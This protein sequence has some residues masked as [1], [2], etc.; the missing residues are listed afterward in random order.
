MR[1]Q[2]PV[3]RQRLAS[4]DGL[5]T[6]IGVRV[7]AYEQSLVTGPHVRLADFLKWA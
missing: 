3:T 5:V 2:S 1:N 7:R 6:H 4:G